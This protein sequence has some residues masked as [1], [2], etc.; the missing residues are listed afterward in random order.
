MLSKSGLHFARFSNLQD[1]KRAMTLYCSNT[2]SQNYEKIEKLRLF[3]ELLK[4]DNQSNYLI[5]K[6]DLSTE[7]IFQ[8]IE[9]AIEMLEHDPYSTTCPQIYLAIQK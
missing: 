1:P 6:A 5:N 7:T 4:F 9:D 8:L 3:T 2:K